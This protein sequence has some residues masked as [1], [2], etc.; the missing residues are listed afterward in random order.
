MDTVK[1]GSAVLGGGRT[2]VIVPLTGGTPGGLAEDARAMADIP[3]DIAEW[4]IDHMDGWR[5]G[6]LLLSCLEML[7]RELRVPL[8]ATLRTAGEGGRAC[9]S[10]G[11]YASLCGL[12]CESG[13]VDALDVEAFSMG[14]KVAADVISH[15][16]ACGL[17][18]VAS[19]HDFASTPPREEIVRR[20]RRM[21][22]A[23]GADAL[24]IAD[25]PRTPADVLT[26]LAA[27]DEMRTLHARKPLI[28]M[29]MGPLGVVSRICGH[30][31]GSAADFVC[32]RAT[33]APGQMDA[34]EL[35]TV[36]RALERT[37]AKK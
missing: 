8:L 27:T 11:E 35:R 22:D 16:H 33:S 4:R 26:L 34:G 25:M 7:R 23:L 9:A 19:S 5:S 30:Y 37:A 14:G 3:A 12:L 31:F 1:I 10:P 6:S 21:Q 28:T 13:M 24:K 17:P 32:G 15:A 20:L 29:S 18:A 36:L 2:L